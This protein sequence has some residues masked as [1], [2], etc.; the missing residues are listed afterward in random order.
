MYLHATSADVFRPI[1][2]HSAGF[3]LSARNIANLVWLETSSKIW[4]VSS[5][6]CLQTGLAHFF[7]SA[8]RP[9]TWL[10][11]FYMKVPPFFGKFNIRSKMG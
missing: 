5:D 7:H 4:I 8:G 1:K 3:L 10:Q 9:G 6:T 11:G 2:S